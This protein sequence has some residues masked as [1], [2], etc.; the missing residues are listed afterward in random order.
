MNGLSL[1]INS[2]KIDGCSN[3]NTEELFHINIEDFW[4]EGE[5]IE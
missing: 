5:K 2:L 3:H 1:R 4:S